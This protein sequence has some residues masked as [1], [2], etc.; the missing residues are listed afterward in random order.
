MDSFIVNAMYIIDKH[1]L[2]LMV[3]NIIKKYEKIWSNGS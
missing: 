1:D 3:Q 2:Y